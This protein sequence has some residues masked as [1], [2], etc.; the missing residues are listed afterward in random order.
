MN[1]ALRRAFSVGLALFYFLGQSVFASS[2]EA[3][4]WSDR[5]RSISQETDESVRY[6]SLLGR[7]TPNSL[8]A[9]DSALRDRSLTKALHPEKI[10]TAGPLNNL[11]AS[12]PLDR[13]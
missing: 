4:F 13:F 8:G 3:S 7:P 11:M 12:V 9:I 1:P 2:P 10:L 6:A 5:R